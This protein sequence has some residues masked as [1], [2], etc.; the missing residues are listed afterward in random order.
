MSAFTVIASASAVTN[1]SKYAFVLLVV[2]PAAVVKVKFLSDADP[3]AT[4]LNNML[5]TTAF[6]SLA[7]G[8]HQL[9][10]PEL[11]ESQH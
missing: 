11:D 1:D 6:V 7:R 5:H 2:R 3:G 4:H 8:D 9:C 10:R